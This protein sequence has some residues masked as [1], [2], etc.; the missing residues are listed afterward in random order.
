MLNNRNFC[1]TLFE[2][3]HKGKENYGKTSLVPGKKRIDFFA[4]FFWLIV[5]K[6]SV[7]LWKNLRY[8]NSHYFLKYQFTNTTI[9][10]RFFLFLDSSNADVV[11]CCSFPGCFYR[12][13]CWEKR[14]VGKFQ[15][16]SGDIF[17]L[18]KLIAALDNLSVQMYLALISQQLVAP[19][20]SRH[21]TDQI[22]SSLPTKKA[23]K[24]S[25]QGDRPE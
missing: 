11:V 13:S 7:F 22:F 12:H 8:W 1:G 17:K 9:I 24:I 16:S 5:N 2:T 14:M 23:V 15:Q 25:I 10:L 6:G 4:F 19:F 18:N 3:I 20:F 21:D